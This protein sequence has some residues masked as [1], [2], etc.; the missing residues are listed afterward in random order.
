VSV[1]RAHVD[2][3]GLLTTC[4]IEAL[5]EIT[6]T[7]ETYVAATGLLKTAVALSPVIPL[8]IA[9][10]SLAMGSGSSNFA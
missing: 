2:L 5:D 6:A 4:V 1:T 10:I 7:V 9:S 3:L 8:M